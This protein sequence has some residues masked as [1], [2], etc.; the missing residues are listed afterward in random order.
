MKETS[1]QIFYFSGTGNTLLLVDQ[2]VEILMHEKIEYDVKRIETNPVV[3]P[4][5]D[6]IL[7][8]PIACFS[9]QSM[10]LSSSPVQL[11]L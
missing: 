10:A 2:I 8:F 4:Q 1:Y 9:T 6:I 7:A 3:D 5:K 11:S